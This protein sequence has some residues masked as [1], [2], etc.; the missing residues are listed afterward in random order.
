MEK[1]AERF[2]WSMEL[3]EAVI[4]RQIEQTKALASGLKD[5]LKD[6]LKSD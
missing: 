5:I 2:N 3:Q 1:K 6:Y 4:Q